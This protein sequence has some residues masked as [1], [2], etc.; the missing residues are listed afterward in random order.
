MGDIKQVFWYMHHFA[1]ICLFQ[2]CKYL[3]YNHFLK[4]Q[5]T[6]TPFKCDFLKKKIIEEDVAY[7]VF[8]C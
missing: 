6:R 7:R 8:K 1:Y 2:V 3:E 4:I 5:V